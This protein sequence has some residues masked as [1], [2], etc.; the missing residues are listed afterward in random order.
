MKKICAVLVIAVIMMMSPFAYAAPDEMEVGFDAVLFR[1][2]GVAAL[3]G[4]A[5][6]FV[7]TLPFAAITRSIDTT[8]E[9]MVKEPFRYT[10]IRPIGENRSIF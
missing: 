3:I 6:A 10:F 2:L 7:V 9:T 4:G 1:P 5:V 8:A